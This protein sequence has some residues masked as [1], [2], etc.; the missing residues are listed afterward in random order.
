MKIGYLYG[1]NAYPLRGGHSVHAYQLISWFTR[2]GHTVHT[3]GDSTTPGITRYAADDEGI[4]AFLSS[5]DVLYVRVH[6]WYLGDEP[7]KLRAM[8]R[9]RVPI[10][11]E[12][13]AP[14]NEILAPYRIDRDGVSL[15]SLGAIV[16]R[17]RRRVRA[18]RLLPG[19][20]RDEALR[21]RYARM[22]D[23][24]ICVSEE[25][26]RY[27]RESLHISSTRVLPNGSD[28][29]LFN[30]QR[31]PAS[32]PPRYQG[33]FKVVY[34]G[35][36][37]FAWQ[38]LDI[39][40]A[41][42]QRVGAATDKVLFIVLANQS[43]RYTPRGEN[44]LVFDSVSYFDVARYVVAADACVCLCRDFT[45]SR[46]GFHGS[47]T[48]LFDYMACGQ[49]VIASNVGQLRQVIDNGVDG[50]LVENDP[51]DL[52]EKILF[53]SRRRD[54]LPEMGRRARQKIVEY[55][56]WERVADATLDI[57]GSLQRHTSD[58]R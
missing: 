42:A 10:V 18:I 52:A 33:H 44:I 28:P 1:F 36:P 17:A 31:G 56:N 54:L 45:W 41:A 37:R 21:R 26:E 2:R 57:F 22:V 43:S 47:P 32:L 5:I 6:G 49:P 40:Q 55:Y 46:W 38:G 12:V 20:Y 7:I 35:S 27:A 9:T 3:I 16:R 58:G 8:D 23:V 11:W 19:I 50:L 39:L 29:E 30:P 25:I 51:R 4:D 24:A 14:N 53:L 13:N 15:T 48:K 34:A